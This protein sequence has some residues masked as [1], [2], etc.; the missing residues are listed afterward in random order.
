MMTDTVR[1]MREKPMHQIED[2]TRG[3]RSNYNETVRAN[4]RR[5]DAGKPMKRLPKGRMAS[6]TYRK[7]GGKR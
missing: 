5:A 3:R 7:S 2:A 6:K 1:T 4:N